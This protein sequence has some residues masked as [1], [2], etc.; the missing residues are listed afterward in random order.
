MTGVSRDLRIVLDANVLVSAL[1]QPVGPS[2]VIVRRILSA[3]H[4]RL[5]LSQPIMDEFRRCL[6]YPR[7]AKHLH[8]SQTEM[9]ELFVSL[10]VLAEKVD[11]T[12][13]ETEAPCRDPEDEKYLVTA[14]VGHADYLVTGDDDLLVMQMIRHIP[15]LNPRDFLR[16]IT[17]YPSSFSHP[18][19]SRPPPSRP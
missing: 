13:R 18:E 3:E 19:T 5:V 12:G 8:M 10:E 7:L 11:L 16:K 2:G 15:I 14:V 4:L 9:D 17:S 6:G 1:I